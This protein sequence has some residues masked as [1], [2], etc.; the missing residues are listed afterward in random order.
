MLQKSKQYR[1][2]AMTPAKFIASMAYKLP[3]L[4]FWGIRLKR[5]EED[6]CTVSLPY[7]FRSKNPFKS[8]YF[9][10]LNGAGELSTGLL[11]QMHSQDFGK[12]S[13]VVVEFQSKF[14]KK[15]K[16]TTFFTCNDGVNI[17]SVLEKLT[18]GGTDTI[19]TYSQ[20][21][22]ENGNKLCEMWVTWSFKKND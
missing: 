8:I 19:K 13:M 7:N 11:C 10:A 2:Q 22:D 3:S 21:T 14:Y 6:T 4:I 20:G 5:L 15:A 18:S 16:G 12:I 9:S 17:R 1:D